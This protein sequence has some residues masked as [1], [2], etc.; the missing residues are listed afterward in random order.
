M[1]SLRLNNTAGSDPG[2]AAAVALA[3]ILAEEQVVREE[4]DQEEEVV[5]F[6]YPIPETLPSMGGSHRMDFQLTDT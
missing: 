4:L 1:S 6:T 3:A 5:G 2:T